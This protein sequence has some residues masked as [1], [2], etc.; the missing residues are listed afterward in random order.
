METPLDRAAAFIR[1]GELDDALAA[2]DQHL[3]AH[4][5]DDDARRLRIDVLLRLPARA[6][7]ALA[8]LQ[9]LPELTEEDTIARLGV[10]IRLG[11]SDALD[12]TL[13]GA[14][15]R[16]PD[17]LALAD[18]LLARLYARRSSDRALELLADLPKS[19]Q[20]L[21]WGGDFFALKGDDRSAAEHF[22]SALDQ[23]GE[24][25][26]P[27][28]Q[29]QK[30][31]LLLKRADA[32]RRLKQY[33]DAD[34][35]YQAAAVIIPDDPMIPFNRGLLIFEQGNLRGA[36]PLCR[37]ALDHAPD[38]LR[39]RMRDVLYDDPRYGALAQALLG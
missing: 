15:A 10:L 4:P 12:T 26:D 2:L 17:S 5:D 33:A 19:W 38:A 27:L 36:L 14:Y 3:E 1:A 24:S 13:E 7:D 18:L 25:K 37:E 28:L 11:A 8:A 32:Y 9:A 34:A 16:F 39:D 23:I 29:L 31:T 6:D 20:M 22:C 30:A 21:R 35:D